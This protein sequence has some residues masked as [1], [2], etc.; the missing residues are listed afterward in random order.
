MPKKAKSKKQFR[1]FY[2][3]FGKKKAKEMTAGNDFSSLPEKV[4]KKRLESNAS[5]KS[6]K[7][8]SK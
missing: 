6:R 7:K 1:L 5:K 2:A 8:R 4:K 3:K